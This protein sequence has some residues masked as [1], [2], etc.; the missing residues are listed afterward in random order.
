MY[1]CYKGKHQ[2]KTHGV[3]YTRCMCYKLFFYILFFFKLF[4]FEFIH[5][6]GFYIHMYVIKELPK[7]NPKPVFFSFMCVDGWMK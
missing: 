5:I 7:G 1:M 4:Y 3:S 6:T 2:D